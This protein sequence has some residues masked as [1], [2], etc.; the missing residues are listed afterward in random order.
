MTNP[1]DY[2]YEYSTEATLVVTFLSILI[3]FGLIGSFFSIKPK[4]LNLL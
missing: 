2:S 1:N 4:L 3:L